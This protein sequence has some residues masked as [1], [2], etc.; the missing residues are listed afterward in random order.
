M[1]VS[2]VSGPSAEARAAVRELLTAA[3]LHPSERELDLF[4]RMYPVFRER[5]DDLYTAGSDRYGSP[6]LRYAPGDPL[7][8]PWP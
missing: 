5:V 4:A 6:A 3:G 8:T 2:A 7:P 1:T